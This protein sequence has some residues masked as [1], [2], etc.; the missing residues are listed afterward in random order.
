[1][2]SLDRSCVLMG[3]LH[4]SAGVTLAQRWSGPLQE[5]KT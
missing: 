3:F 2:L 5:Q 1:M 4:T